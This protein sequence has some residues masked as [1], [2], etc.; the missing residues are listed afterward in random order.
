VDV[1]SDLLHRAHVRD[2]V[3]RQSI[4]CPPWSVHLADPEPL[5]AVATLK[6]GASI[7]LRTDAVRTPARAPATCILGEGD[8]A[9]VK[10]G[11]YVIAD[12]PSTPCQVIVRAGRKRVIGTGEGAAG[13]ER[14]TAPRTFGDRQPGA[15]TLLHGIYT[16]H[17][18]VGDWLLTMLPDLV[19]VP[20]C[21]RTRPPLELL[22]AEAELDEAGQD[23]V[24]SRVLDLVLVIALRSW[25]TTTQTWLGA[26]ADPAIGEALAMLHTDPRQR[27][28]TEALA[29]RV[30]MSRATF[31]ARFHRLVGVPPISYL[32]GWRMTLAAD[33][34]RDTN[35]TVA[36]V[37]HELGYENAFA[38]STAFKR[39]HGRSPTAWR[40]TDYRT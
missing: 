8:I 18:S 31:S 29:R 9:L 2:A 36:A 7:T 30:G 10:G 23:A 16:L 4:Q 20:A 24:L 28:T 6:G 14:M 26:V 25:G 35:A 12:D 3:V 1:L 32:T 15:T 34:L 39:A 13:A 11:D 37:A 33:M 40:G 38:F 21:A 19:V 5:T 27:W 22:S 17:G